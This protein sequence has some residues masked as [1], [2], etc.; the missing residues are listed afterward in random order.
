VLEFFK[1][2]QFQLALLFVTW[3]KLSIKDRG[4]TG[5]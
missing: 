1:V 5:L 2:K 4:W 3:L